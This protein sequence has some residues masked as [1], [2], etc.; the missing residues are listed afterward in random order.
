MSEDKI[1]H[2]FP[3]RDLPECPVTIER[4]TGFC[5]H[6]EISLVEHDRQVTC[7][8]CGAT[9]DAFDYLMKEAVAIRSG[10]EKYRHVTTMVNEKLQK[11]AELEKQRKRLQGQI[12]TLNL[13][14]KRD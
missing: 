3:S 2:A 11:I 5:L 1:I 14:G 10:W 4:R 7:A 9:L 12:R 13:R 8:E 6:P